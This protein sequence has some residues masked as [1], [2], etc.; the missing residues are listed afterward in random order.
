MSD[1]VGKDEFPEEELRK[2]IPALP[3]LQSMQITLAERGHVIC[4]FTP[5]KESMN[6]H[7]NVHG[8]FIYMMGEVVAGMGCTTCGRDN[9]ALT[10]NINYIRKCPIAPLEIE[11]TTDHCGRSTAVHKVVVRSD[12]GKLISET[13]FTMFLL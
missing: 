12:D 9:V 11:C 6:Y 7:G 4:R 1:Y 13:T 8:G 10:G 2:N 3:E 5:P